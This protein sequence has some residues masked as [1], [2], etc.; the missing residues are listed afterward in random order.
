MLS[1]FIFQKLFTKSFIATVLRYALTAVGGWLI[2]Q[3]KIDPGQWETIAGA[4]LV[5]IT[6]LAGGT[7]STT[8]KVVQD[9][10]VVATTKLPAT[11]RN[12]ITAA[13]PSEKARSFI[14]ILLGK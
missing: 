7:D 10:K 6:A 13:I 12:A 5:I 11:V 2:S 3:G 8:D 4:I 1:T 14:D 9:G